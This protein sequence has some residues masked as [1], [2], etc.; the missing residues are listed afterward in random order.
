MI[1]EATETIIETL[2]ETG[3]EKKFTWHDNDRNLISV[4]CQYNDNDIFKSVYKGE[5]G[6]LPDQFSIRYIE[7]GS[8][9][10]FSKRLFPKF[11]KDLKTPPDYLSYSVIF[12]FKRNKYIYDTTIEF[13]GIISNI[14]KKKNLD[15]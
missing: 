8:I 13:A 9:E 5:I 2:D 15:V 3:D 14:E 1:K 11:L 10:T 6:N 12:V 4:N 7:I